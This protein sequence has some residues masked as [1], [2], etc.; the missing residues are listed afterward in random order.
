MPPSGVK[1]RR[2][3]RSDQT[4]STC[5]WPIPRGS[6]ADFLGMSSAPSQH[7]ALLTLATLISQGLCMSSP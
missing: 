5:R 2:G 4:W 1:E 3:Q 7:R 6:Q